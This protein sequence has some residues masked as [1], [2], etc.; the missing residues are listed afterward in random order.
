LTTPPASI[1]SSASTNDFGNRSISL[2]QSH[3]DFHLCS[4]GSYAASIQTS[5]TSKYDWNSDGPRI[6]IPVPGFLALLWLFVV[7]RENTRLVLISWFMAA[8][9]P[10]VGS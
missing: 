10:L 6:N 1:A 3:Q 7:D 9:L 4:T 5:Q 2:K 8:L